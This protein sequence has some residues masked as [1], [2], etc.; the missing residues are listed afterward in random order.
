MPAL[1]E[2]RNLKTYFPILQGVIRRPVGFVKAVDD[3][4]LRIVPGQWLGMVGE[5]GCGK[6]TLG[7]TILRLIEA[8][9]GNIYFNIP[10]DILDEIETAKKNQNDQQLQYL[11]NQYDLTTYSRDRLKGLR[12]NMQ[13]VHQDPFSSLNPRMKIKDII[14]EPMQ[15]HN[16]GSKQD[17]FE[18]VNELIRLVGLSENHVNRYPHQ[19]SGGQRQRIAIAR[20]LATTPKFIVFDEPTS[21][22]DVSVQAQILILL[23]EL[24]EKFNL[25]YLYITHALTVA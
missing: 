4:D 15:V 7:K 16:M 19:F 14:A 21:A 10:D 2:A 3:V 18:R 1:I 12:K 11:N 23:K 20:A 6:T 5:S 17:I 24:K 13:L 22:L 25:T 8:T 9:S